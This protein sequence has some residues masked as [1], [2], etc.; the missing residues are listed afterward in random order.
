MTGPALRKQASQTET[1]LSLHGPTTPAEND[2]AETYPIVPRRALT[3]QASHTNPS[4]A[5]P[6]TGMRYPTVPAP[7]CLLQGATHLCVPHHADA[8]HACP[9]APKR[10]MSC[11]ALP[12]LPGLTTTCPIQPHRACRTLPQMDEPRR[13]KPCLDRRWPPMQ[14]EPALP[15][16]TRT[17]QS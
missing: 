12:A 10:V 3:Y 2:P 6:I 11:V 7:P 14:A 13:K 15:R 4:L 16:L 17:R 8:R 5:R 1:K 9:I